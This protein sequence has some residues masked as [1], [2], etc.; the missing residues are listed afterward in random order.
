MRRIRRKETRV[1]QLVGLI[2][3]MVGSMLVIQ[4]VPLAVCYIILNILIMMLLLLLFLF[5]KLP[6]G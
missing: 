6:K 3:A 2:L 4:T 1:K 5:E